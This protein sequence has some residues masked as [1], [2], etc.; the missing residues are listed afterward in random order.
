MLASCVRWRLFLLLSD[1]GLWVMRGK[2]SSR[3][4]LQRGQHILVA[5]ACASGCPWNWTCRLR[6]RAPAVLL[7]AASRKV[8]LVSSSA[9][10]QSDTL[11]GT[12]TRSAKPNGEK[13]KARASWDERT[14]SNRAVFFHHSLLSRYFG[15]FYSFCQVFLDLFRPAAAAPAAVVTIARGVGALL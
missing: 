13:R 3:L 14:A 10:L 11:A 4:I 8:S 15:G 7:W 6:A 1:E 9:P 12:W 5:S 2:K